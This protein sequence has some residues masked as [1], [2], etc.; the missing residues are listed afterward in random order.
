MSHSF[1][2]VIF[3]TDFCMLLHSFLGYHSTCS[4]TPPD[5]VYCSWSPTGSLVSCCSPVPVSKN[6]SSCILSYNTSHFWW[7][8]FHYS[9]VLH[10]CPY[11]VWHFCLGTSWHFCSGMREVLSMNS[12]ALFCIIL[13]IVFTSMC[14]FPVSQISS[15]IFLFSIVSKMSV[16]KPLNHSY[17]GISGVPV[18]H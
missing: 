6:T 18:L 12:V 7:Y 15:D 13:V 17:H 2:R 1:S 5:T 3:F 8:S 14:I 4:L 9:L 10:C 16:Y 11:R